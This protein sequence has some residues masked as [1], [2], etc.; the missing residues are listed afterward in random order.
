M[1]IWYDSSVAGAGVQTLYIVTYPAGT[2]L[3]SNTQ[4]V[5]GQNASGA[6]ASWAGNAEWTGS[7]QYLEATGLD[8]STEYDSAAVI[9]DGVTYSNVVEV[10]GTWTT[11]PV[12][13]YSLAEI[14]EYVEANLPV[15]TVSEISNAVWGHATALDFADKML[16]CSR[17]LRNKTVTDPTT[18]IMTVY[19]DDGTTPYLTAQLYEDAAETQ[20]YRG[21]GVEVRRR[22]V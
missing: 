17:I 16:I 5:A 1:R 12:G 8:P 15:P 7:G 21:Q 19:A 10:S 14:L 4:I 9:F 11:A 18:G 20:T 2:G 6:A 13:G 22:L 3:P